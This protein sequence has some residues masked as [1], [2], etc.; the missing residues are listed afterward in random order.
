M[1]FFQS[2]FSYRFDHE[3]IKLF[4]FIFVNQPVHIY[5]ILNHENLSFSEF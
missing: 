2:E 1:K 3:K 4:V 5:T